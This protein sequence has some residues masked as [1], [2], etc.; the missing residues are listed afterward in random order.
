MVKICSLVAKEKYLEI[1]KN[2]ISLCKDI[3]DKISQYHS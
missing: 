2:Q 3:V 1:V